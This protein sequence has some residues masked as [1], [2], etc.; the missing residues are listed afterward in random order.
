MDF[1]ILNGLL[2]ILFVLN[3]FLVDFNGLIVSFSGCLMLLRVF[4]DVFF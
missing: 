3:G 4:L 2:V 1:W